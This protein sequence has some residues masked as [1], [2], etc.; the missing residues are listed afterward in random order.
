M[1]PALD[2]TEQALVAEMFL[3]LALKTDLSWGVLYLLL[4]LHLLGWFLMLCFTSKCCRT[5]SQLSPGIWP[6]LLPVPLSVQ[7]QDPKNQILPGDHSMYISGPRL[8]SEVK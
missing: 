3:C 6:L 1:N 8:Y 2:P 7:F 5:L 4:L